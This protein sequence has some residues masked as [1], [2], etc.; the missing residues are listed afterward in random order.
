MEVGDRVQ[1]RHGFSLAEKT[2]TITKQYDDS[3]FDGE[4]AGEVVVKF[5]DGSSLVCELNFLEPI[6]TRHKKGDRVQVTKGIYAGKYGAVTLVERHRHTGRLQV[7]V[8]LDC[9]HF[10]FD[11]RDLLSAA[12]HSE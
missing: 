11:P 7:F 1:V 9:G 6:A 5:N 10:H 4:L 12:K 2:G 3:E 8:Q